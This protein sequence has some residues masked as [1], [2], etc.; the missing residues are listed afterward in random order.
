MLRAPGDETKVKLRVRPEDVPGRR[1]RLITGLVLVL[2]CLLP[3]LRGTMLLSEPYG[4]SHDGRNG[5]TWALAAESLRDDPI[6]SR[7]GA[8]RSDGTVYANHPPGLTVA[9]AAGEALVGAIPGVHRGLMVMALGAAIAL[10][11]WLLKELDYRTWLAL[12]GAAAMAT[13]PMARAYGSMVDTPIIALP[14]AVAALVAFVRSGRAGPFPRWGLAVL[15]IGPLVSWQLVLLEGIL[16][17]ALLADGTRRRHLVPAFMATGAGSVVLVAWLFWVH[18][19]LGPI[20]DQFLLRSSLDGSVSGGPAVAL[21]YQAAVLPGLLGATALAIPVGAFRRHRASRWVFALGGLAVLVYSAVLANGAANHDYWAYWSILLVALGMG[22]TAELAWEWL[23]RE[24]KP[25]LYRAGALGGL[26]IMPLLLNYGL[27]SD[28]ERSNLAGVRAGEIV[29]STNLPPSQEALWLLAD[30]RPADAWIRSAGVESE[31]LTPDG[32]DAA[33]RAGREEE[34]VLASSACSVPG[35]ACDTL[36]FE[37]DDPD[38]YPERRFFLLRI[39][40]LE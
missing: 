1:R 12:I 40:D 19:G 16:C 3:V 32:L 4:D 36:P 38:R 25:I 37:V 29:D 34:L 20:A 8:V 28:Q 6:G 15:A 31:Y 22:S 26:V 7:L 24:R 33:R 14:L 30:V 39:T 10:T 27:V 13:T 5:A 2:I 17:A 18:G 9:L 21:D 35:L 23:S 11:Y